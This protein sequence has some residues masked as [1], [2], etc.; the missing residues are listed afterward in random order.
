MKERA[1]VKNMSL[2]TAILTIFFMVLVVIYQTTSSHR[3]L[4]TDLTIAFSD[5]KNNVVK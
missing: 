2:L 5:Y 3:D 1:I 4:A